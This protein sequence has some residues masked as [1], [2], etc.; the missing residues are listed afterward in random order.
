MLN[1]RSGDQFSQKLQ[2][3]F[4]FQRFSPNAK[5]ERLINET[6]N[7]LNSA[8]TN[9]RQ[10]QE[11]DLAFINAAGECLDNFPKQP[12]NFSKQNPKL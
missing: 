12:T 1:N 11:E 4:D 2:S 6:E 3:L 7:R 8:K 9:Q 5:L 10:L